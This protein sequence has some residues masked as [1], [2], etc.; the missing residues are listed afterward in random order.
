MK[1]KKLKALITAKQACYKAIAEHINRTLISCSKNAQHNNRT[2]TSFTVDITEIDDPS[3]PEYQRVHASY[4]VSYGSTRSEW[5]KYET[6]FY[7]LET[8]NADY[9]N[10]RASE[11]S[12]SINKFK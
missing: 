11:L 4:S 5:G 12:T 8:G 2:K 10:R 1:A 6:G 7:K 9:I 3:F